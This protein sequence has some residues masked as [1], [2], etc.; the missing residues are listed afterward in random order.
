MSDPWWTR[1]DVD[2]WSSS[3]KVQKNQDESKRS[4][5]VAQALIETIAK[6]GASRQVVAASTSALFRLVM[7]SDNQAKPHRDEIDEHCLSESGVADVALLL[8]K[9][10]S[11]ARSK[12]FKTLRDALVDCRN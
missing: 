6:S 10:L 8:Q 7:K 11:S 9:Q 3:L 4:P 5:E 2:P 12:P 1:Q